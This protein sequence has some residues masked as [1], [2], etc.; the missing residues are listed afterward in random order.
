MTFINQSQ[1]FTD[2]DK[3]EIGILGEAGIRYKFNPRTHLTCGIRYTGAQRSYF[4]NP[5]QQGGGSANLGS[6]RIGIGLAILF[7]I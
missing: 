6:K 3:P 2:F 7:H 5:G 4:V 1:P